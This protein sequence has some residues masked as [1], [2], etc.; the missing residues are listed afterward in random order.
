MKN[1]G[2]KTAILRSFFSNLPAAGKTDARTRM[3]NNEVYKAHA[4]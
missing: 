3:Y 1:A 4:A 2:L